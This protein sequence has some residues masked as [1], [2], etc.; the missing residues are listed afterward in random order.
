MK[1]CLTKDAPA[2]AHPDSSG[3]LDSSAQVLLEALMMWVCSFGCREPMFHIWVGKKLLMSFRSAPI[4]L[5]TIVLVVISGD[6]IQ[7][8]KAPIA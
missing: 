8:F 2:L 4:V 7:A 3:R 5:A 6:P 1:R